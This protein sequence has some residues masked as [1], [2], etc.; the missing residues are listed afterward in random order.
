[1]PNCSIPIERAQELRE[2]SRKLL[3]FGYIP[4]KDD[5]VKTRRWCFIGETHRQPL[6]LT[7]AIKD[8]DKKMNLLFTTG[9]EAGRV[10]ETG[11][12]FWYR[13]DEQDDMSSF[14]E[15][16]MTALRS[17]GAMR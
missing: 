7:E 16:V 2:M 12:A 8:L 9:W 10:E 11:E 6:I 4:V 3:A 1:M 17:M 13:S 15:A 14:T 5:R